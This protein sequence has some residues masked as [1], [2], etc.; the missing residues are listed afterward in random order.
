MI[1]KLSL[2]LLSLFILNGTTYAE[3]VEAPKEEENEDVAYLTSDRRGDAIPVER[4]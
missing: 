3:P 1:K 4:R 2:L